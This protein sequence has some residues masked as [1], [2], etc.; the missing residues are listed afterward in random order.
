MKPFQISRHSLADMEEAVAYLAQDSE[1]AAH[2]L[3]DDLEAAFL[4]LGQW[5]LSGHLRTD[6]TSA[7]LR[8]WTAGGY[9]IAYQ[10]HPRP[11]TIIA[12][13][14]GSRDAASILKNR[15]P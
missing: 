3:V 2:R 8:F 15:L 9:L 13:L 14:H 11:V 10:P 4:F 1:Q 5:P 6:L 12:I 7:P